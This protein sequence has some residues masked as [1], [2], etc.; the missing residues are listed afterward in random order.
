MSC[1]VMSCDVSAVH[2]NNESE[3]KLERSTDHIYIYTHL[4]Y[5][6]CVGLRMG[7]GTRQETG[8]LARCPSTSDT[9]Q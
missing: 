8:T 1:H 2:R 6:L 3:G 9:T 5:I 4:C 7:Y